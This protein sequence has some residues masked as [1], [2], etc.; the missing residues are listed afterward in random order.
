MRLDNFTDV[1]FFYCL[2]DSRAVTCRVNLR[3]HHARI[4]RNYYVIQKWERVRAIQTVLHELK[5]KT[6]LGP[7]TSLFLVVGEHK[8]RN[9]VQVVQLL[10]LTE[11]N[12]GMIGSFSCDPV[13]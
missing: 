13:Q 2:S 5:N 7:S 3:F 8:S 12:G 1:F 11:V 6:V 10:E 9:G 4:R